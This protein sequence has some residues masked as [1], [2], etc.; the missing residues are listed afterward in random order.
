M[1]HK[2]PLIQDHCSH[3]GWGNDQR[4]QALRENEILNF[5]CVGM[6]WHK[7][8]QKATQVQVERGDQGLPMQQVPAR[9][10]AQWW[11]QELNRDDHQGLLSAQLHHLCILI[12]LEKAQHWPTHNRLILVCHLHQELA[13]WEWRH[14]FQPRGKIVY[15]RHQPRVR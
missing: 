14:H 2:L 9:C 12:D 7:H 13:P 8:N 15:F 6:L 3:P 11:E 5:R 4:L 10:L 1:G